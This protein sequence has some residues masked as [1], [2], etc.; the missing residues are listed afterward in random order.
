MCLVNI[1]VYTHR[2]GLLSAS[3]RGASCCSGWQRCIAGQSAEKERL[4]ADPKWDDYSNTPPY[5]GSTG[6]AEEESR[7]TRRELEA[8]KKCWEMLSSG[9]DTVIRLLYLHQL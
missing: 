6:I 9:N 8:R 5:L 1:C 7:D 4:R 2:Q 3:V